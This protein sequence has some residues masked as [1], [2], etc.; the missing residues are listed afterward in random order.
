ME[1]TIEPTYVTTPFDGITLLGQ[2][3]LDR[4]YTIPAADQ[5]ITFLESHGQVP[6]YK[7]ATFQLSADVR[8]TEIDLPQRPVSFWRSALAEV[9]QWHRD[10][11]PI[12]QWLALWASADGTEITNDGGSTIYKIPDRMVAI[13]DNEAFLHRAPKDAANRLFARAMVHAPSTATRPVRPVQE[14]A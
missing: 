10:V 4:T 13:L 1:P 11:T 7:K 3:D 5:F 12:P 2:F 14:A 8:D 9:Q 6:Y